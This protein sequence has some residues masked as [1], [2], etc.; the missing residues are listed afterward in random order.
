MHIIMQDQDNR[1]LRNRLLAAALM[2][3]SFLVLLAHARE[4]YFGP[5][6]SS[7]AL[8]KGPATLFQNPVMTASDMRPHFDLAAPYELTAQ[9]LQEVGPIPPDEWSI[10]QGR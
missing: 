4:L 1:I 2:A 8:D 6:K 5:S 7:S 9:E 3:I 10:L